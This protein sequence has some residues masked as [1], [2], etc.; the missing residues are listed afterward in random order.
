MI[1]F[2]LYSAYLSAADPVVLG[3]SG[4]DSR[5]L[6]G[7][8]LVLAV[9]IF[10][11]GFERYRTTFSKTEFLVA[12]L[13]SV[14]TLVIGV[15]PDV[16]DRLG[17]ALKID[18]RSFAISLVVNTAVVFIILYLLA[19]MRANQQSV[20]DLTRTLAIEQADNDDAPNEPTVCVVIPA[21]N[22]AESIRGV[23][24]S[25]P[26]VVHDHTLTSLVVSDGSTDGTAARLESTDAMVVIH[27][28]NQGQ[29]SALR[30]GF[31]IAGQNG[32]DI[33]V[34]MDANGQ[35]PVEQLDALI[36]PIVTG[37]ADYVV[38]SRYIGA[39]SSGN[40]VHRRFGIRA[41]T[42]LIN[43]M[44][45][46]GITDC[47]NGFRAIRTSTLSEFTLTEERFSAPELLIEARKNGLRI[48]EIP[49]TV[50][51]REAGNTK[52]PTLGDALGLTRTIF[53]TW[54]R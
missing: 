11:W 43:A 47:T 29:G 4:L 30:T 49:I 44:T 22:E 2:S 6:T 1:P 9:V 13:L 21:Y 50:T 3:A 54:I 38:G 31:E 14:G 10:L 19:Q 45:K 35:H 25:L 17:E 20:A 36:E 15:F 48:L 41:L 53:I 27:P 32:A 12:L 52:K 39:D 28:I 40:T 42:T 51:Q 7:V 37:K 33:V 46:A 23:V 16:F 18:Q 5:E 24:E 8:L 34:T 26:D